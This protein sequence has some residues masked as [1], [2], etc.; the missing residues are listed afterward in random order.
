IIILFT[1]PLAKRLRGLGVSTI[2]DIAL[3]RFPNSKRI[4]YIL[5]ITQVIWG[6]FVAAL[7]V[8]GGS[9][10]ITSVTAIPLTMSLVVIVGVTLGYTILG[11]RKSTRL[12]SSH[13]S[14]SYT[15]SCLKKNKHNKII[16]I[17]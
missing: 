14:I 10:L 9:L 11:D 1:I 8:F 4:H 15:V 17:I 3:A 6:I 7:S 16:K 5:T 2:A 13:V 12:N